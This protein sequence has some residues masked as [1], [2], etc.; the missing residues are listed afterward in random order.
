MK[1]QQEAGELWVSLKFQKS[2]L[3]VSLAFKILLLDYLWSVL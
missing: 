2:P 3:T 1:Q